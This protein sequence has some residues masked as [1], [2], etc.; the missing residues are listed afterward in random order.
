MDHQNKESAGLHRCG[1]KLRAAAPANSA[2]LQDSK[3]ADDGDGNDF[4]PFCAGQ[5]GKKGAAVFTDDDGDGGGGAASRKPV[6]PTHDES[7]AAAKPAA[8]EIVLAAAAGNR[9]TASGTGAGA[10][11]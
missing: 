1:G 10:A 11:E 6:A 2:P 3:S 9:G 8:R 7:G 4:Y 5:N